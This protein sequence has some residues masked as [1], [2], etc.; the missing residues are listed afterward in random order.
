MPRVIAWIVIGAVGVAAASALIAQAPERLRPIVIMPVL[1]GALTGFALGALA[2]EWRLPR[3]KWLAVLAA[4]LAVGGL[5]NVARLSF[6]RLAAAARRNVQEDPQQLI[7]LQ[8]LEQDLEGGTAGARQYELSRL[9]LKPRFG[10]YLMGR[11]LGV[12]WCPRPWPSV[13]WGAESLAAGGVAGWIMHR[14]QRAV[15]QA[16]TKVGTEQSGSG[17]ERGAE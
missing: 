7:G 15:N 9:R 16:E 13:V 6:D 3:S 2:T 12:G 14:K 1:F 17:A 10:D 8:L 11:L 4:L 5:I